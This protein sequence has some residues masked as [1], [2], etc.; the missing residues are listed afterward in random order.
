MNLYEVIYWS[1]HGKSNSEDTIYLVRAPDFL[2][3]VE[4]VRCNTSLS[5]HSGILAHIV[6]EI[7]VDLSPTADSDSPRT[8]RGPYFSFAYNCGWRS[9]ERQM[10]GSEYTTEWKEVNS[11]RQS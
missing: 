7:G 9:W 6:Y 3:A 10:K 2:A 8:I 11:P 1:S 5:D 4:H